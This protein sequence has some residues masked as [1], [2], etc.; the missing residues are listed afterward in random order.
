MIAST[1]LHLLY[2]VTKTK[3]IQIHMMKN[4]F[5]TPQTLR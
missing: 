1:H 2:K 4:T 3:G 5:G